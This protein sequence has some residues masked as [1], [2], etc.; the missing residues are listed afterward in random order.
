LNYVPDPEQRNIRTEVKNKKNNQAP[1]GRIGGRGK[2]ISGYCW[3]LSDG[4]VCA[5]RLRMQR[6]QEV[7]KDTCRAKNI[8][9][10]GGKNEGDLIQ[11]QSDAYE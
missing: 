4:C 2:G 5:L 9:R 7:K 8:T 3:W 11:N 10:E 1:D 6:Q